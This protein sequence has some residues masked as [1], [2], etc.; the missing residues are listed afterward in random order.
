MPEPRQRIHLPDGREARLREGEHADSLDVDPTGGPGNY[1]GIT[2][3]LVPVAVK[4]ATPDEATARLA[5]AIDAVVKAVEEDEH[6][7]LATDSVEHGQ[8]VVQALEITH[9]AYSAMA[10][11]AA[12]KAALEASTAAAR[13][14]RQ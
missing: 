2:V 10:A 12:A 5:P 9:A 11:A 7:F 3:A 14:R 8:A 13:A 1:S 4:A 6:A